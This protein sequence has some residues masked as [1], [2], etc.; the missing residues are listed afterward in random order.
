MPRRNSPDRLRLIAAYASAV[1]LTALFLVVRLELGLAINRP[2]LVLFVIPIVTSAYL[3]GFAPGLL[4]TVLAA[5]GAKYFFLPNVGSFRFAE[6]ISLL[7][8]VV[9]WIVGIGISLVSGGMHRT[10]KRLRFQLDLTERI[11]DTAAVSILV[12]DS[13]G[14]TTFINPEMQKVFG[15][16][17]E[18]L[19]GQRIHEKIHHHYP[20]GRPFPAAECPFVQVFKTGKVLR[21]HEDVYF[22]KDGTH[23]PVLCSN[24]AIMDSGKVIGAVFIV[25]DITERKRTEARLNEAIIARNGLLSFVSHDLKNPLSVID[26][27]TLFLIR[28]CTAGCS[29]HLILETAQRIRKSS[30]QMSR[31]ISDLLDLSSI[32]AGHFQIQPAVVQVGD[33]MD[34]AIE[35]LR[36]LAE[37]KKIRLEVDASYRTVEIVYDRDRI[38]QV[39]SNIIGNAIKFTE[40]RGSVV[41][42]S[43]Q[44][45]GD[46]VTFVVSDNGPGVSPNE[47][48]HIF[49]R[50]WHSNRTKRAGTGLGLAIS[51]EIV[52]A[53]QGRIWVEST[54]GQGSRF[55]FTAPKVDSAVGKALLQ[56]SEK[57][58]MAG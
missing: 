4:A 12:L 48:P 41:Q 39:F 3:G 54:V 55:Y 47:M 49:D 26:L 45:S 24:A 35:S 40:E 50:F 8:W 1:L 44:V 38:A 6:T 5:L 9:L 34:K 53:H 42:V 29:S 56:S 27:A 15:F 20:D 32:E 14:N 43:C 22:H 37:A 16:S 51:Q 31:L 46:W 36:P 28:N 17:L 33:V 7:H 25:Y 23:I 30:T 13:K 57:S 21:D 11:M 19:R 10:Q 52:K 18:E 58:R 2:V